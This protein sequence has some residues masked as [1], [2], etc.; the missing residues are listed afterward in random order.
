MPGLLIKVGHNQFFTKQQKSELWQNESVI[1][2]ADIWN[3]AQMIE[4]SLI[5]WEMSIIW[6]GEM[7]I[8]CLLFLLSNGCYID[9]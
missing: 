9:T 2:A 6:K 7:L 1:F 3:V 5:G 4:L 8:T